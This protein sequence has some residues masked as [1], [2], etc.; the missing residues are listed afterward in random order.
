MAA[1]RTSGQPCAAGSATTS[2]AAIDFET[3]NYSQRSACAIGVVI[4]RDG[5][6]VDRVNQLIR[7]PSRDFTFTHI[8]GLTWQD[9][10]DAPTFAE[11]WPELSARLIGVAFLAAHNA[12]FD[13]GVLAACCASYG[14][15]TV[16]TPFACTVRIARS[17]WSIHPTRLPDVCRHLGIRLRHHDAGSDAEA[18]AN[19][20][21]AAMASG[22]NPPFLGARGNILVTN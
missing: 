12:P 6:V 5:Q 21:L 9:V 15:P 18:C 17:V 8:H 4:V 1:D 16:E 19:I 14:L 3:A 7:P 20:V 11:L 22:W 2:F 13:R 10:R